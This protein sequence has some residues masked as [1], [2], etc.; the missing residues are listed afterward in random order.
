MPSLRATWP[1]REHDG[2][3][4][5]GL[6]WRPI[7]FHEIDASGTAAPAAVLHDC[8]ALGSMTRRVAFV[9]GTLLPG[10]LTG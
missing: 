9:V 1:T 10:L 5:P 8:P 7:W 6:P 4:A 2:R 3:G